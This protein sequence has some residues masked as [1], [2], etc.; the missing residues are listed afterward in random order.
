MAALNT[1]DSLKINEFI[2]NNQLVEEPTD[3]GYFS[4]LEI[5]QALFPRSKNDYHKRRGCRSAEDFRKFI[6][7][8]PS[9]FK[10]SGNRVN[11]QV[12]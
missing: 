10:V 11:P 12:S 7:S 1:D 2:G 8:D 6:K 3:A 5:F 4:G 9:F